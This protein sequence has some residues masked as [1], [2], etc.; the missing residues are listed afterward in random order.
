MENPYSFTRWI[1]AGRDLNL[2]TSV[3]VS[4]SK[5]LILRSG[6]W[7]KD[8]FLYLVIR[9]RHNYHSRKCSHTKSCSLIGTSRYTNTH[10]RTHARANAWGSRHG[11]SLHRGSD[12]A[13]SSA[14]PAS[15]RIPADQV[16][17]HSALPTP[18]GRLNRFKAE[19]LVGSDVHPRVS[20]KC[21]P[22]PRAPKE[23][24]IQSPP[25]CRNPA[26]VWGTTCGSSAD[27]RGWGRV[28]ENHSARP[29]FR[30]WR[31]PSMV[32]LEGSLF[33]PWGLLGLVVCLRAPAPRV[34][35]G[36]GSLACHSPWGR[37]K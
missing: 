3:S 24:A 14:S 16:V 22:T 20:G 7:L 27:S 26:R 10:T 11:R 33:P 35:D 34:G 9:W 21:S 4:G 17:S 31:G 25:R 19:T 8:K 36:P 12:S 5:I 32:I 6:R 1:T 29:Q 13:S 30:L 2:T 15:C 23:P 28:G 37:K 18:Q